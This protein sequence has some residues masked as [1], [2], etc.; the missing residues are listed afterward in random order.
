MLKDRRILIGIIV[1]G[2]LILL[3][4]V[5]SG[6]INIPSSVQSVYYGVL[7]KATGTNNNVDAIASLHKATKVRKVGPG[8]KIILTYKYSK[9]DRSIITRDSAKCMACHGNMLERD[10]NNKPKHY[11]HNKMLSAPMLNF[12]CTDCHKN[13]DTRKRTPEHATLRVDRTLCPKCHDPSAPAPPAESTGGI[14]WGNP[15]APEMP[16]I[17][18]KHGKDPKAGKWWIMNHP[19]FAMSIGVDKCRKCHKVGSELDI[20]RQ[21]HLRGGFR[22]SSHRVY[23]TAKIKEIYP[24]FATGSYKGALTNP[25][26]VVTTNWKGYHF[27]FARNALAKMGVKV[28]NP[29]E[30]PLD[31][32]QKLPCAACHVVKEW[33]TKCHIKH[34]PNWLNPNL[35][36]PKKV[37]EFGTKYCTRCHD[38]NG[39]KCVGCHTFFGTLK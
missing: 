18:K 26:K 30:L 33:C 7:F 22:P 21:C 19:R 13:V 31:K 38:A 35:G 16:N 12:S 2:I 11:I 37:F 10:E 6:I 23:F 32:V 4:S 8:G 36:H 5:A 25:D 17:F 34:N 29:Q 27:V 39:S 14:T 15:N 3:T 24:E 9:E 28:T 1:L 20:C